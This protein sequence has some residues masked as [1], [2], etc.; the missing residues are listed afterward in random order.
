MAGIQKL[1][2]LEE[3]DREWRCCEGSQNFCRCQPPAMRYKDHWKT[4]GRGLACLL[5]P[6]P[7]FGSHLQVGRGTSNLDPFRYPKEHTTERAV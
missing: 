3:E 7:T 5:V 6:R 4:S 1:R 2:V